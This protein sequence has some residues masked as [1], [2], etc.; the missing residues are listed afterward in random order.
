MG[1]ALMPPQP[2]A[3]ETRQPAG[4]ALRRVEDWLRHDRG[5]RRVLQPSPRLT[6]VE[7]TG[8]GRSEYTYDRRGDVVAIVEASGARTTYAYDHLR[9]L[10]RVDQPAGTTHYTYGES[11]RLVG[12]DDRGT[13]R[14]FEHDETGRI[15]RI[16]PGGALPV[17]YRWDARGRPGTVALGDQVIARYDYDDARRLQSVRFANGVVE[18]TRADPVDA[19]PLR[20]EVL[21]GGQVLFERAYAYGPSGQLVADGQRRYAYDELGRMVAVEDPRSGARWRYRYDGQD[22]RTEAEAA[23]AEAVTGSWRC[24]YDAENR[25]V[26]LHAGGE[27]VPVEH[28]RL[29]RR[30]RTGQWAYRYDDAAQLVQVRRLGDRVARLTYDHKGR[31]VLARFAD[32]AERY[33]YGPDDELVAV[34]DE[35]GRPQRLFVRT[36][37]G[38]LAELRGPVEAGEVLFLH[39]DHQGTCHLATD[40]SG[41]VAAR[42]AYSP[43]GLPLAA[44]GALRPLFGGRLW[45]PELRLYAVGARWYDPE[46]GRFLTPDSYTGAPDDERLVHPLWP[47]SRQALARGQILGDWLRR[48]RVRNRYAY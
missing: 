31:L 10:V 13:A 16:Q 5:Q 1:G 2:P 34:T 44:P 24:G 42:L 23:E 3:P 35:A 17:G 46:L 37:L 27:R 12:V 32:R 8:A 6:V 30:T 7:E 29:G 18:R 21:R 39:T 40:R 4:E 20:R 48:P 47:A 45:H 11:D 14:R 28:D 19:R 25:L 41:E 26:E 36:P 38:P 9:R 22:N 15:T 33:L 43:F